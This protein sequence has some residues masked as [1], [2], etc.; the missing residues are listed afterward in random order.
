MRNLRIPRQRSHQKDNFRIK[1]RLNLV[2]IALL[3][4]VL[5]I[6]PTTVVII[7]KMTK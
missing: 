1:P 6:I 7:N 5:V 4:D 2:R 3:I